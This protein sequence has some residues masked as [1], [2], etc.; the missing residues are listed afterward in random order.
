M[1]LFTNPNQIENKSY[2]THCNIRNMVSKKTPFIREIQLNHSNLNRFK[3]N[4]Y[5]DNVVSSNCNIKNGLDNIELW[6]N[7]FEDSK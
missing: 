1:I 4:C 2:N 7:N 6:S 5:S 3:S